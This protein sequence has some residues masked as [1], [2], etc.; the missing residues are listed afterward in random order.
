MAWL[1][2][3]DMAPCTSLRGVVDYV[4]KYA[5]KVEK[6]STSYTK[7]ATSLLRIVSNDRPFQSLVTKLM[8]QLLGEHDWSGQEVCHYI[9]DLPLINSSRV[10]LSVDMRHGS[11]QADMYFF[12]GEDARKGKSVVQ[13]YKER[14]EEHDTLTILEFI[15]KFRHQPPYKERSRGGDRIINY[16]PRYKREQVEDYARCK[17]M[18]HQHFRTVDDVKPVINQTF[19]TFF[20]AWE[21]WQQVYVDVNVTSDG[22][23]DLEEMEPEESIHEDDTPD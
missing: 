20:E 21:E 15:R 5:A 1:A 4:V 7:L 2:N 22:F 8:N 10:V 19:N 16:N 23:D 18:L 9:L 11:Q 3:I 14:G 6:N 13:K 12:E 17:L